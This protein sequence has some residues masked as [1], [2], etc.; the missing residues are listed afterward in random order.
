VSPE[1]ISWTKTGQTE[2]IAGY[3]AE[4]WIGKDN[5]TGG[6]LV[7]VWVGGSPALIKEYIESLGKMGS[8]MIAGLAEQL[9]QSPGEGPF[10]Y[11]YP[12]KTI[13]YNELGS[14][15]STTLVKR[16]DDSAIDP[17]WFSV[18]AGY[19]EFKMPSMDQM[20]GGPPPGE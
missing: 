17:K 2:Q 12:L 13:T 8:G 18:P 5:T 3:A 15:V 19:Q 20:N 9:K 11:G 7:E 10:R 6:T 1:K 16:M 4:Q 14:P